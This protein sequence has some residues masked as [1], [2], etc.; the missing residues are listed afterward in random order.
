VKVNLEGRVSQKQYRGVWVF[1]EQNDGQ[2]VDVTLEL[3]GK[4]RELADKLMTDLAGVLLGYQVEHCTERLFACGADRVY[5]VDNPLLETYQADA[6]VPVLQ[7][8]VEEHQPEILLL[9]A[10]GVG[11]DLAPC[12]AARLETG[13]SAHCIDLDVDEAGRLVQVVPAFGQAC[14]ATILC[15]ERYPQMA[16][17]RPGTFP[18]SLCPGRKGEIIKVSAGLSADQV[19]T[20]VVERGT[21]ASSEGAQLEKAE[22]VVAGGAGIGSVEG[23]RLL[24]QLADAL[25]G[26]VGASRPAVDEGWA[27]LDRMIGH[28]GKRVRPKLY[29]GVGISGDMLHM[30]GMKDA[31]VAVAINS[32]PRA[33]IFQQ[34][35]IGIVGDYRKILPLLM[36]ELRSRP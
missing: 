7:R 10:T 32:D 22:I 23:W 20:V 18:I 4:G 8:L 14:A 13:L 33:P 31:Q 26:T 9:G 21:T 36:Q 12:L 27:S 1:A 24:E 29:I 17:V 19:R 16:T 30:I 2:L 11:L 15:P 6:Y 35:D 28:S 3:L 5:M 34:V 25:G